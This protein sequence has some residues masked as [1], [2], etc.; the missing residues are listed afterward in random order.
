MNTCRIKCLS[1]EE[2]KRLLKVL[3]DTKSAWRDR[4]VITLFLNTG[5]R[6]SEL[7]GLNI[8]S[9]ALKSDVK[10]NLIVLGKGQKLREIPL[11][12]QTRTCL[13]EFLALKAKRGESVEPD[14]PLFVSRCKSR[15]CHTAIQRLL[16]KWVRV[17][18]FEREYYPHALRHTFATRLYERTKNL[19]GVQILLGHSQ[20]GT[21]QI[22]THV[23][24]S[25][26]AEMTETLNAG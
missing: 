20:I 7:W 6:L 18:G 14:A 11:N 10:K 21:T 22:Y 4:M 3:S 23:S 12:L 26:L 19:R 16:L 5:L 8:S 13:G 15:L 1:E 2:S 25:Q 17:A 24:D 9:V